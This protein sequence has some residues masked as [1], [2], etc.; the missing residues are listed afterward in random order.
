MARSQEIA[1]AIIEEENRIARLQS[2]IAGHNAR[3]IRLRQEL[4]AQQS[5]PVLLRPLNDSQG[6]LIIPKYKSEKVALFRSLFR[7][8]ED[9]FPRRWENQKTGRAGYAPAC[10]NDWVRGV[11]AK[12]KGFEKARKGICAECTNQAFIPISDEEITKH[13]TGAHIM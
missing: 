2:E 11:C 9:I 10:T 1:E 7:G 4:N 6:E 12:I 8:R 3:L 13:L 5:E